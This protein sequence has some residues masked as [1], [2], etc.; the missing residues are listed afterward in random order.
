LAG[1]FAEVWGASETAAFA[2]LW[3][4]LGKYSA[5]FQALITASDSEAHLEGVATGPRKRSLPG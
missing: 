4:D 5:G 3:H 2:A 1:R